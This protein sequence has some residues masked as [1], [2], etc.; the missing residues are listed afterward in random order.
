MKAQVALDK[1]TCLFAKIGFG[2]VLTYKVLCIV[3]SFFHLRFT[4]Q[5]LKYHP[6]FISISTAILENKCATYCLH[7]YL[8]HISVLF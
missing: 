7:V 4:S 5:V 1:F 6:F 8:Y 3:H 2:F